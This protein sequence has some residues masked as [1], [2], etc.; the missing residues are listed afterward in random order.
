MYKDRKLATA[1]QISYA[2]AISDELGFDVHFPD[3]STF[4]D[5]SMFIREN[6][7]IYKSYLRARLASFRQID[8]ANAIANTCGINKHFHELSLYSEVNDFIQKHVDEYK[9]ITW[10]TEIIESSDSYE[11]SI[12]SKKSLL[13]VCDNLYKK[14]GLYAF[15][16]GD[17]QILY[18]GK[19]FDLS[20]RITTSYAARKQQADISG[21][22]YYTM[23][24]MADVNILEILLICE[25]KPLL[26]TESKTNDM[27]SMFHSGINI[28]MDFS[29]L[30]VKEME[31]GNNE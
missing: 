22:M 25:N 19:S 30:P 24:N 4:Y 20:Q 16:G 1:K 29:K 15:I 18:I 11:D 26:N 21:I 8:Y 13:F 7:S 6:E 3:T 5:V 14:H 12:F 23:D 9:R 10:R 31:E 2:N 27:P 28:L 17:G